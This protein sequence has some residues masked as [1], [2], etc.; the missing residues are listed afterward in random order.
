MEP[1]RLHDLQRILQEK[2]ITWVA[3][4]NPFALLTEEEKKN[5]LGL[6]DNVD[7]RGRRGM[8]E[9][10][11]SGS[12]PDSIDW[13]NHNGNHV[14]PVKDQH[15]CGSCVSFATVAVTESMASIEMDLTLD[16]SERDQHYC[17]SHGANCEGWNPGPAF[18]E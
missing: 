1:L 4:E 11:K 12:F 16:L 17:S 7:P 9:Y 2:K 6:I 15:N 14:T 5:R 18:E 8:H 13:R 10:L 3:K